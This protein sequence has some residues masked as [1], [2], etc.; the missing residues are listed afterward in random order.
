MSKKLTTEIFIERANIIHNHKYL[1]DKA[2]YTSNTNKVII[3]CKTHGDFSQTSGSHLQGAGCR[4]CHIENKNETSYKEQKVL[5]INKF[6]LKYG[7]YYDYS[8]FEYN[9]IDNESIFICPIHGKF[10]QSPYRHLNSKIGCFKCSVDYR[11][12]KNRKLPIELTKLKKNYKRRIKTFINGRGI[13][14]REEVESILGLNWSLFKDYLEDNPYGFKLRDKN[15]DLD[16]I[17]PLSSATTEDDF[18]KLS[19]YTNF[20]L[21]PRVYNQQIKRDKVFNRGDFEKWLKIN[22]GE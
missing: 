2:N 17:I 21:L 8:L 10:Y 11:A 13:R 1:Y 19:H 22:Y 4:K 15:L 9:G 16:H 6:K 20:Q 5:F 12:N 7:D 3:T 14:K 18:I